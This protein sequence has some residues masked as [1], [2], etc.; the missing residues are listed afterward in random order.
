[1][2]A[3]TW[4][5]HNN[6]RFVLVSFQ[7]KKSNNLTFMAT[8]VEPPLG[9]APMTPNPF[10]IKHMNFVVSLFYG[11]TFPC[12]TMKVW[13]VLRRAE[14]SLDVLS[15]P[16]SFTSPSCALRFL[17]PCGHFKA[18]LPPFP[19][20]CLFKGRTSKE[21]PSPLDLDNEWK[22][23]C[24]GN[25]SL[26]LGTFSFPLLFFKIVVVSMS[27]RLPQFHPCLLQQGKKSFLGP[28]LFSAQPHPSPSS[29]FYFYEE[30]LLRP[31]PSLP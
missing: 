19:L 9:V 24:L 17:F 5:R 29:S 4:C 27:P 25:S 2:Y 6:T 20:P 7:A 18:R 30:G 16:I 15:T 14:N 12:C 28:K 22:S 31:P 10:A 21:S 1:M 3:S 26:G 23:T 8:L 11:A 13:K